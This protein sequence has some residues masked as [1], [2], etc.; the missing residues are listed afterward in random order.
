MS[1]ATE[2]VTTML[3]YESIGGGHVSRNEAE[4]LAG[5]VVEALTEAGFDLT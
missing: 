4:R 2:I 5:E 3:V 1:R